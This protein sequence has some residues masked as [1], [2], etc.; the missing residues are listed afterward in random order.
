MVNCAF[1]LGSS[2]FLNKTKIFTVMCLVEPIVRLFAICSSH[3]YLYL[4]FAEIILL[5]RNYLFTKIFAKL[6]LRHNP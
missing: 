4:L 2:Y 5:Y 6:F 1:N 3:M